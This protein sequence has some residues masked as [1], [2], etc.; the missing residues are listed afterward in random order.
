[1][2]GRW[3]RKDYLE[4]NHGRFFVS[5]VELPRD[6]ITEDHPFETMVFPMDP[7][8]TIVFME[9]FCGRYGSR[10]EA[11]RGHEDV[12]SRFDP[13]TRSLQ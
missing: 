12:L 6:M 5:T 4:R 8:G 3:Q 9:L 13:M 7:D 2:F 1:M 10:E 11:E